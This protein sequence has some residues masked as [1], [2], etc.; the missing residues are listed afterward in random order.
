MK[1]GRVFGKVAG[2][3]STVLLLIYVLSGVCIST[4]QSLSV[5]RETPF[6]KACSTCITVR[7]CSVFVR[8]VRTAMRVRLICTM[9]FP[10]YN[11][12]ES[13]DGEVCPD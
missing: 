6:L 9:N 13:V 7:L 4:S 8:F 11:R 12:P 2:K 10:I 5:V 1:V 3:E